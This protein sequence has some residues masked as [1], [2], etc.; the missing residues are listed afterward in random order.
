MIRRL[1][2]NR[3]EKSQAFDKENTKCEKELHHLGTC[4]NVVWALLCG[5]KDDGS[6]AEG[7]NNATHNAVVHGTVGFCLE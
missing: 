7:G 3:K 6:E 2:K 5:E 1:G 4:C